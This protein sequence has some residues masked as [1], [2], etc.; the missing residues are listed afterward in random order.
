MALH[1]Y[2]EYL[3][4]AAYIAVTLGLPCSRSSCSRAHCAKLL[5]HDCKRAV[6]KDLPAYCTRA[7]CRSAEPVTRVPH[8]PPD[9]H[10]GTSVAHRL[11]LR[12][13][14]LQDWIQSAAAT[15]LAPSV[16]ALRGD[17]HQV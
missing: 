10:V 17:T 13:C 15:Q 8:I 3:Q 6:D 1:W 11:P 16:C 4:Q 14:P 2:A 12:V 7:P 9:S 5:P